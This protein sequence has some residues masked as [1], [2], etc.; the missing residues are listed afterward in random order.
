MVGWSAAARMTAA[1]LVL[2]REFLGLT[3]NWIAKAAHVSAR[4]E[5]R[6]ESGQ[7]E[8]PDGVQA[9][10]ETLESSASDAV[11]WLRTQLGRLTGAGVLLLRTDEDYLAACTGGIAM[12]ARWHR[13]VAARI[14]LDD[15]GLTIAFQG[16]TAPDGPWL[17]PVIAVGDLGVRL[18]EIH[19][20][21]TMHGFPN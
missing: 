18:D 3:G 16:E 8:I 15:P 5:R 1:E 17:R 13:H 19:Y 20:S 11:S 2:A 4:T 12:P 10:I 7:T 6:W 14:V 21:S 9:I